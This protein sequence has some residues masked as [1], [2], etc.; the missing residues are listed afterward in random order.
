MDIKSIEPTPSPNTM[1]IN[2]TEELSSGKSNNYKKDQAE[3]AP[4][5]VK[6]ILQVDGVKGVYHVA[7]FLAVE[8]NPKF[9]WKEILIKVRQCFGEDTGKEQGENTM[10]DHYGEV[11]VLIQQFKGIPMQIKLNDGT[12]EKRFALPDYFVK[13]MADAQAPEDNVVLLRKWKDYGV[14][15]GDMDAIGAEVSEELIAAYP[16]ER[17][18]MLVSAAQNDDGKKGAVI[19][20]NKRKL[21]EEVFAEEDWKKRYQALEQMDDPTVE[22]I[23]LLDR[24]LD[25]SKQS[26][27]RLAVVYLGM[28]EDKQVLP[29]LYK[30]LNDKNPAVRRTAGDCLS[31]LGFEEA[32]DEMAK[33]LSDKNKIVR[34][35]AAM[36]LY[37]SGAERVLPALKNAENDPE[38]EVAMQ[39]K[40]AIERIETGEEAKGSV[41]KQMTESRQT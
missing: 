11:S 8:R 30:G 5:V 10:L 2:L 36:F 32:M 23:P 34:W 16:E 38:F 28:I 24:A 3:A 14:R 13:T 22:D 12:T 21:T 26:I 29:A 6:A 27:R 17:L 7:D 9:D 25:D 40:M 19:K 4:A 37:E 31:D 15:Y 1:K 33:T 18:N 35:R 39:A 41:W 20:R